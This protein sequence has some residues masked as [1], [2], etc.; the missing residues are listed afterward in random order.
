MIYGIGIDAADINR[1][2]DAVRNP[3][4]VSRIFSIE[5]AQSVGSGRDSIRRWA[6][7]FAGK[8]ALIKACGGIHH[9]RWKD[10]EIIRRVR[11]EPE[12]RI[13]GP[14]GEWIA[15]RQLKIWMS[16]THERQ[17]AIAVVVLEQGSLAK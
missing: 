14:L 10:I 11:E 15:E 12:V 6:A 17:Y 7:R 13:Q 5:E 8:E 3:R 4:F 16:F 9:S 2:A 1:I